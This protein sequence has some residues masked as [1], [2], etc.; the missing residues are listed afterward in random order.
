VYPYFSIASAIFLSRLRLSSSILP[1]NILSSACQKVRVLL[2][3]DGLVPA[4]EEVPGLIVAFVPRLS[5]Y[6]V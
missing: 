6:T 5:E 4:L 1:V 2:D 3:E